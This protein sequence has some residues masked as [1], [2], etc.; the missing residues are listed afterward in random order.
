MSADGYLYFGDVRGGGVHR[1]SPDGTVEIVVP[2]RK[3]VGGTC[4]H[5][6]GGIVVS[7]RDVSHVHEGQTRVI[8]AREDVDAVEGLTVGGFNDIGA[9]P[10][11]RIFAGVQRMT[12]GGGYG[13]GL[14]VMITAQHAG[15]V[16]FDGLLPNGNAVSPDERNLY[17]I[18][19]IGRRVLVL[20]LH[21]Q[22]PGVAREFTTEMLPGVPDGA[23]VDEH[24]DLWIAFHHGGCVG[25]FHADGRFVDSIEFPTPTVT[26][27][28]FGAPGSGHLYVVTDD[29]SESNDPKGGIYRLDVGVSGAPVHAARV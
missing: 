9:D 21:E 26:S 29:E 3:G 4:L 1:L 23:A 5:A 13:P 8:F 2:K 25:R 22:V 20:D 12:P 16:V 15:F 27:L 17:Q 28:C 18:D 6:D 11:G 10:A 24:G 7:G 14:L 19:S